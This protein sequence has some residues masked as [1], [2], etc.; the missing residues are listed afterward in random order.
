M[1]RPWRIQYEDAY[2]H[3]L[4]RGNEGR[5][6]FYDD[7]DRM[8]FLETLGEASDRFGASIYAFV[9]MTNHYHLLLQTGGANLSKA[10]Q[11]FG[12]TYTRR[13]NN[14]HSRSGHLFQ[15][16]FKSMLIENDAYVV[17]LSCYIHRNPLR[18]GMVERLID[19]K[20]SSYPVY[21]YG[22][23]GPGWLKTD[24]IL[25][26]FS[27]EDPRKAY[28]EK[29]QAYAGEEKRLWEDFRH[30]VILGT[31]QFV[32]VIKTRYA[33]GRP[34]P[35]IPRQRGVVGRAGAEAA[36]KKDFGDGF[37]EKGRVYGKEKEK[38]DLWVFLLW[39][40]G[41]Y[42]NR[43]IGDMFGISYTAVSHIV[44]NAKNRMKNDQGFQK[45]YVL[46]NSQIKM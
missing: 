37:K 41:A 11:W 15:G 2:Y 44:K 6:I 35:E 16:R 36:L 23:K 33:G 1:A 4:S 43:E 32:D 19:Y 25:G 5:A 45:D 26:Y 17:E 46:L 42:T 21:A 12:V 3:V 7:Q 13:F 31:S 22:R 27:G 10:M 28:R 40:S 39:E 18:A 14:R 20:W 34:H 9:V 30:G 24:L 29:V 38:R 8:M